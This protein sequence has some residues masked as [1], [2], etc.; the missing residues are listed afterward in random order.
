MLPWMALNSGEVA[1]D[2]VGLA[3]VGLL[4][5]VGWWVGEGEERGGEGTERST[6][7]SS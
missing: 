4:V 3:G 5:G 6:R 1:L 2:W 7:S